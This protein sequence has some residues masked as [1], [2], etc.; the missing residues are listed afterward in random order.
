MG[1]FFDVLSS[2]NNPNQSGSV[3]QLSTLTNAAQQLGAGNGVNASMLQTALSTVGGSLLPVLKQ[4]SLAPGGNQALAGLLNQFT[5]A[6]VGAGTAALPSFLTPQLQQ[7]IVQAISHKTGLSA[8]VLQPLLLGLIA[9][10][11]GFLG[12]GASKPGVPGGNSIL[13]TFLDSDRDG[14]TDLGDVFKFANRFINVP[15]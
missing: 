7:Q 3:E 13:N 5:G 14:D 6:G 8:A 10:A 2:I 12:M 1:L 15:S 4:Q 11:M 9:T